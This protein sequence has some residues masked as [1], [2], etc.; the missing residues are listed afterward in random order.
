MNVHRSCHLAF[1]DKKI[2]EPVYESNTTP[3][4]PESEYADV[5]VK[6]D[7]VTSAIVRVLT[8]STTDRCGSVNYDVRRRS[9]DAHVCKAG[10][11]ESD[12]KLE[13]CEQALK[14]KIQLPAPK[15]MNLSLDMNAI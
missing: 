11:A 7:E 8:H 4:T 6:N 14:L 1:L 2:L 9:P 13:T 15:L 12:I 5:R 10:V 3:K